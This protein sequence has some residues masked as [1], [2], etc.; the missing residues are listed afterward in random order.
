MKE[1]LRC[2]RY[3]RY[4]DDMVVFDNDKGRLHEIREAMI[5]AL[6]EK[7]LRIHEQR[8]QI[9]PVAQGTDWLGYRVY[10]THRRLRKSNIR[11][12]RSRMKGYIRA[13]RE[14]AVAI[15]KVTASVM[16]WVAYAR[17]ADSYKIRRKV[18]GEMVFQRGQ[19]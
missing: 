17:N 18:F 13:Y 4:M 6:E 15:D 2:R 3:I 12:F 7:R 16:S 11:M 9:W 10:P 8:G 1:T 14:G 5:A 19:A